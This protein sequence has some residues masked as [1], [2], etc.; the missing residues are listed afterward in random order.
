M[1]ACLPQGARPGPRLPG[2]RP[3][4]RATR[5]RSPTRASPR[6]SSDDAVFLLASDAPPPRGVRDFVDAVER[7]ERDAYSDLNPGGACDLTRAE[8]RLLEGKESARGWALGGIERAA[9]TTGA[10]LKMETAR[11]LVDAGFGTPFAEGWLDPGWLTVL[12]ANAEAAAVEHVVEACVEAFT[13]DADVTNGGAETTTRT[14]TGI[15]GVVVLAPYRPAWPSPRARKS[16]SSAKFRAAAA[17]P[18]AFGGDVAKALDA[19][20]RFL[21]NQDDAETRVAAVV[22]GNPSPATGRVVSSRTVAAVYAWCDERG[23]H[24]VADE[25]CALAADVRSSRVGGEDDVH[26]V[27]A[28][29]DDARRDHDADEENACVL[30]EVR[31]GIAWG[32]AA[33]FASA[34]SLWRKKQAAREKRHAVASFGAA[35]GARRGKTTCF[36]ITRS[37]AKSGGPIVRGDPFAAQ[38]QG[39]LADGGVAARD[40]FGLHAAALRERRRF[41]KARL[42]RAGVAT[43]A[44]KGADDGGLHVWAD[45]RPFL[46]R[47]GN[48]DGDRDAE[49][50]LFRALA[51]E[52]GVTLVPGSLCGAGEPG[53]FRLAV[54]GEEATLREGLDRLERWILSRGS[55]DDAPS[56]A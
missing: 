23:A 20:E 2:R 34:T 54:A 50:E 12:G 41:A 3:R 46:R 49:A 38:L 30:R 9:P 19:A 40:A 37:A 6:S 43:G 29:K 51:R 25:T 4:A 5:V 8:S 45:L 17:D 13:A 39:L 27:F 16:S 44:P 21:R 52:N 33:G 56:R 22:F 14:A 24:A 36:F 35:G 10:E 15:P 31:D 11:V 18:S 48:G 7:A 47:H 53:F 32:R 55:G 28:G 26:D 1:A 42:R